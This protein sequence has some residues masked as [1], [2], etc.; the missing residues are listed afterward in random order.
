MTKSWVAPRIQVDEP[1]L[2]KT[3]EEILRT[4]LAASI[5]ITSLKREP[6][7]Y[8][9]A[10]PADVLSLE[11]S[12][13]DQLKLFLK[14]LSDKDSEHPDKSGPDREIEI[15][16]TL[17]RG[18][19]LPVPKVC[20]CRWNNVS[21]RHELF[22][23]YLDAW[24]LQHYE[25][26]H[27]VTAVKRLAH[28][29]LYF[30]NRLETLRSCSS[31]NR[32]DYSYF[33]SWADRALAAVSSRQERLGRL[34]EAVVADYVKVARLLA[35][36]PVTLVHNEL[37]PQNVIFDPSS[38]PA[39]VYFVDWEMAGLGCPL[40]DPVHL[41]QGLNPESDRRLVNAYCTELEGTHLIP[42]RQDD[43]RR[44]LAACELHKTMFRLA[45]C[46]PWELPVETID[47]WVAESE[48]FLSRV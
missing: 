7:L 10:F 23:E 34:L 11:L 44:L 33:V 16:T 18:S 45:H 17:F 9:T 47:Q 13:G 26:K 28:F 4:E 15:Y 43:F 19:D 29:H 1:A 48:Q 8:A 39:R 3:V 5:R 32:F 2:R 20:G 27:W 6:C 46:E 42:S 14:H 36:Q 40:L 30:A 22:L 31:L 38:R 25:V 41:K 12:S 21:K 37:T 24:R 35:Q